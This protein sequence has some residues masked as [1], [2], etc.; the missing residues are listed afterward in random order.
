M[1]YSR[2]TLM[3]LQQQGIQDI[4]SSA[5]PGVDSMLAVGFLPVLSYVMAGYAYEHYGYQDWIAE[6]A[7][8]WTATDEYLAGWA[9]LKGVYQTPATAAIGTVSFTGGGDVPMGTIINRSDGFAFRTTA[10]TI[11]PANSTAAVPVQAITPGVSGSTAIGTGFF[12]ATPL[13]G[14]GSSGIAASAFS[15]AADVETQDAFRSRTMQVWANPAQGGSANDY[16]QWALQVPGVSKAWVFGNAMGIGTV[17]VFFLMNPSTPTKGF[18]SGTNGGAT[19]ESRIVAATGDQLAVANWIWP[20]RPVTAIVYALSPVANPINY[21]IAN[22]LPSTTAVQAGIAASLAAMHQT[23]AAPGGT[24]YQSDWDMAISAA[25]GVLHFT[26]NNLQTPI[27]AP[28]G[29]IL[30][31]GTI[32]FI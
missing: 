10:D 26:V 13:S 2:P 32:T 12:L 29:T 22:L 21:T 3:Q 7:V 20:L 5:I 18:P 9:A 23:N 4:Q 16:V 27:V 1:P 14:I 8:P 30:T 15:G 24:L 17:S 25:P 28:Y 19:Q 6:Q 11:I 31:L